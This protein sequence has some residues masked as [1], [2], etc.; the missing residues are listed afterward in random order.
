MSTNFKEFRLDVAKGPTDYAIGNRKP[1]PVPEHV[2]QFHKAVHFEASRRI[3]K[4]TP[5]DLGTAKFS[6]HSTVGSPSSSKRKATINALV[7]LAP[8][9][10]SFITNNQDY[11]LVLEEGLFKPPDPGGWP[12][13][14]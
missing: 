11:I 10:I 2:L 4:R 3:V 14:R 5:R 7:T 12:G 1:A 13:R 9:S 6:W 8:F